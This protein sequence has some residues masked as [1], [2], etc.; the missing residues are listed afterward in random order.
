MKRSCL[1][2][3]FNVFAVLRA[4]ERYWAFGSFGNSALGD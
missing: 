3:P 2:K 1:R 4:N